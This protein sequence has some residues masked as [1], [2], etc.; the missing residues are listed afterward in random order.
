MLHEMLD[1]TTCII[2]EEAAKISYM[3][4]CTT[5]VNFAHSNTC[6]MH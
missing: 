3:Q 5:H 2:L 4:V 1:I 6:D